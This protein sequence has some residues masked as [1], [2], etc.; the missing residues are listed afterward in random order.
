M[1]CLFHEP[2]V[3]CR[4]LLRLPEISCKVA[5]S[6]LNKVCHWALPVHFAIVAGTKFRTDIA[7]ST[8]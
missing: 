7:S 3:A 5:T 8:H 4:K 1:T 2:V 6:P